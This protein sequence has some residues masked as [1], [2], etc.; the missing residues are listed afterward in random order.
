MVTGVAEAEAE[1][2]SAKETTEK[3]DVKSSYHHTKPGN[4]FRVSFCQK[5]RPHQLWQGLSLLFDD[6]IKA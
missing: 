6:F 4:I 1:V 5:E 3:E 2:I